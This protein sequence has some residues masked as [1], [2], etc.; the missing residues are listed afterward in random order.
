M[1]LTS[2]VMRLRY[3]NGRLWVSILSGLYCKNCFKTT[4]KTLPKHIKTPP[5]HTHNHKLIYS[6]YKSLGNIQHLPVH[7][8]KKSFSFLPSFFPFSPP[9]LS[10][11]E[12]CRNLS[13]TAGQ[14]LVITLSPPPASSINTA[15]PSHPAT[16]GDKSWETEP[17]NPQS[18]GHK[19]QASAYT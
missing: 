8:T 12:S 9:F 2:V 6:E 5:L 14:Q 4:T 7:V 19:H 16:V 11:L 18:P 15:G 3:E 1:C 10:V 17:W 13:H